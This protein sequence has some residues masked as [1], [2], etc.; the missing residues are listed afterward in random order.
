VRSHLALGL[1][2]G[3]LGVASGCSDDSSR[4][5]QYKPPSDAAIASSPKTCSEIRAGEPMGTTVSLDNEI[6]GCAV[7]GM[8]C[9]LSGVSS[10]AAVCDA[11]EAVAL[12]TTKLQWAIGCDAD[13][14]VGDADIL[15]TGLEDSSVS[16]ADS[17]VQDPDSAVEDAADG[18]ANDLDAGDA[19]TEDAEAGSD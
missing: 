10:F 5:A 9:P 12:C 16:D 17:A 4:P 13:A 6:A 14:S 15:D 3:A 1:V 18:D 8:A 11:G 2:L 19:L 7:T